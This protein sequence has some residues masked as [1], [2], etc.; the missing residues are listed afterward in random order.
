VSRLDDLKRQ[1]TALD[2]EIAD[3]EAK[4]AEEEKVNILALFYV[5]VACPTCDGLGNGNRFGGG[6]N[7]DIIDFPCQDCSGH[8]FL[9]ARRWERQT[10]HEMTYNQVSAP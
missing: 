10:I 3:L 5:K 9:W 2:K 1:R 7:D 4:A 6:G 8:G